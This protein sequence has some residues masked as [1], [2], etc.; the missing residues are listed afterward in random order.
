MAVFHP[1]R[2][3]RAK[4]VD[5]LFY[6]R[7]SAALLAIPCDEERFEAWTDE[8]LRRDAQPIEPNKLDR[9]VA[10]ILFTPIDPNVSGL[11]P[12]FPLCIPNESRKPLEAVGHFGVGRQ[13]EE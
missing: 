11:C 10:D 5:W 2:A 6:N 4:F 3:Y 8:A 13:K 9:A 12:L 1:L 7:K